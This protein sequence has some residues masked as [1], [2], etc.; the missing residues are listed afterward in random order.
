MAAGSRS[1]LPLLARG[2]PRKGP[3]YRYT[4][5]VL[6]SSTLE[7]LRHRARST[8]G[9]GQLGFREH[10]FPLLM[11]ELNH[12]YY[13][14]HIR[15]RDGQHAADDFTAAYLTS[16]DDA[17]LIAAH[18]V[19]DVPHLDLEALA[20]PFAGRRFTGPDE[21]SRALTELLRADVAAAALGNVD[22]PLKA[23]LDILRDLRSVLRDA[24]EF[25]GLRPDSCDFD[26]DV[27]PRVSTSFSMRRVETPST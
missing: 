3:R 14:T 18:G 11:R 16:D 10:V 25:G 8:G 15:L 26:R 19:A 6:T 5:R 9:N 13:S 23:A 27:M 21:F 24:V 4:P 17:K 1:G 2:Y 7:Q 22:G 20:R 12:A